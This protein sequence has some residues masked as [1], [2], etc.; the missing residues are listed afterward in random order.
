MKDLVAIHW[1]EPSELEYRDVP[2]PQPVVDSGQ[3]H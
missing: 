2:D 3:M 1:G